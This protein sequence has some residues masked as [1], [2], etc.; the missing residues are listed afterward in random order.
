MTD[1]WLITWD[2]APTS[3]T[4]YRRLAEITGAREVQAGE[5]L[6]AV[7]SVLSN[8]YVVRDRAVAE[9]MAAWLKVNGARVICVPLAGVTVLEDIPPARLREAE[10]LKAD[11]RRGK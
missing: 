1:K 7:E 5:R 3:S 9:R 11:R 4:F 6:P 10:A 2:G 8:V